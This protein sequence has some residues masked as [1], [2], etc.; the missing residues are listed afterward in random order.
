MI[1]RSYIFCTKIIISLYTKIIQCSVPGLLFNSLSCN[2][3]MKRIA[4]KLVLFVKKVRHS[5]IFFIHEF[6]ICPRKPRELFLTGFHSHH[7]LTEY[8]VENIHLTH[9]TSWVSQPLLSF[10]VLTKQVKTEIE[11]TR[12]KYRA[13]P[14]LS[15]WET[16][17]DK[18]TNYTQS[19]FT[20]NRIE[21]FH[22]IKCQNGS[23]RV[24]RVKCQFEKVRF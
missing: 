15:K 10:F 8:M 12:I 24:G 4:N 6:L 23:G 20:N 14:L 9:N 16:H 1:K 11:I 5:I 13:S 22:S 18:K 3:K 17:I 2:D 19:S 21:C 7:T